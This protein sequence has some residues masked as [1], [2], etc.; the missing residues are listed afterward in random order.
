MLRSNYLGKILSNQNDSLK[1][2]RGCNFSFWKDDFV[3][4]NE[5]NEDIKEW[6]KEDSELSMHY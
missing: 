4:V 3:K 6:E 5:Y 2:T 1:G